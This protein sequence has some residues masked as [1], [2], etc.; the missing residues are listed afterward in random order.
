MCWRVATHGGVCLECV[1]M[2]LPIL[3]ICGTHYLRSYKEECVWHVLVCGHQMEC[4]W[5][6][7]T[8]SWDMRGTLPGEFT[9][10]FLAIFGCTDPSLI[11]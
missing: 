6:V 10:L 11:L 9:L 5:H 2:C 3:G 1:G 8:Y 4:T 7:S